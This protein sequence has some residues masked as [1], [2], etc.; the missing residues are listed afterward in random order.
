MSA[1]EQS[2]KTQDPSRRRL[3]EA[4]R[5]GE[6]ARSRDIVSA[7]LLVCACL[8]FWVE[9][10][11]Q[12]TELEK[13]VAL[14]P[15]LTNDNFSE[16]MNRIIDAISQKLV[17]IVL[18]FSLLL[19]F[20]G[21]G[22]HVLQFGF[23]F[24]M[25]KVTP[26][27]S[28]VHPATGIRRIFGLSN[29]LEL[30]K[31]VVKVLVIVV[32]FVLTLVFSMESWFR[33]PW[34]GVDCVLPLLER[35][36]AIVAI[37][38]AVATVVLAIV[39][40]VLQRKLYVRDQ[41][42]TV[43]EMRQEHKDNIGDPQVRGRRRQLHQEAMTDDLIER[44]GQSTVV[45]YDGQDHA[46]ALKYIANDTPL[47]LILATGNNSRGRVIRELGETMG[48]P[49]VRADTVTEQLYSKGEVEQYIPVELIQAVAKVLRP[50]M[51]G[52]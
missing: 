13:I 30:V 34:C 45:L 49:V 33:I 9:W 20:A 6:V 28:R 18:P 29:L 32:I 25:E 16:S 19:L 3:S 31:T 52:V 22:A 8:Y 12:W 14:G 17:G 21:I 48:K 4:R 11:D 50:V 43:Q 47:P 44:V 10:R 41:R 5:R 38:F 1:G 7:V 37:A 35:A 51:S 39:D 15:S 40:L 24:S 46:V 42:M 27:L 23:L 2:S 26:K 36:V